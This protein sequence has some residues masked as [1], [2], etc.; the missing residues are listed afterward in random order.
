[1]YKLKFSKLKTKGTNGKACRG[2]M[3]HNKTL[4]QWNELWKKIASKAVSLYGIN[5]QVKNLERTNAKYCRGYTEQNKTK[6]LNKKK[7]GLCKIIA[8]I[9]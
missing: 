8:F 3:G 1:M 2:H 7:N 6:P 9:R 5:F 4:E